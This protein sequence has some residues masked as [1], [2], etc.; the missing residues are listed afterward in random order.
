MSADLRASILVSV[1]ER[2]RCVHC[3]E[4]I[5]VHEPIVVLAEGQWRDTSVLNELEGVLGD[6]YYDVYFCEAERSRPVDDE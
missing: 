4:V 1:G 6:C 5:G 3:G 2:L